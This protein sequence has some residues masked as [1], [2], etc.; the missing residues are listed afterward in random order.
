MTTVRT[1]LGL[2]GLRPHPSTAQ[3][4]LD[5]AVTRIYV[6]ELP[7][8][9]RYLTAGELVLSGLLW[10]RAPGDA[11]PFVA[12][13]A[14]S[15]AAA[16]AAS[17]ADAGGIPADVVDTCARHGIPLLEVPP[18]LS[19]A[20]V[21]ER[22]VLALAAAADGARKRLLTAAAEDAPLDDLLARAAEELG[23]ACWV[24]SGV[25]RVV[26]G[27][28]ALPVSAAEPVRQF[29]AARARPTAAGGLTVLPVESRHAVPWL[30][31]VDGPLSTAQT[32]LAEELAGLVG[33][34]RA[35]SRLT[36]APLGGQVRAVA[37]RT[38][39]SAEAD[40]VLAELLA[41]TGLAVTPTGSHDHS[42]A[43]ALVA[44]DGSWPAGWADDAVTALSTVEPLLR[45]TRILAGVSDAVPAAESRG[46]FEVARHALSLAAGREGDVVVVPAAE[47]GVHQLLLAGTSVDLRA[48]L[49][50][51]LL[52]PLLD[53]DAEQHSDLVHTV[54]VFLEC[55]GSPTRAAKA[56]H[57]HV[58]TLRYR[59]G[60]A[61]EL[62][63]VDLTDF[64]AQV[65][66]Y[67]TLTSES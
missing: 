33:L 60:R 30:L 50:R 5:R 56:L 17:G 10:W 48:A 57:I 59:I 49:R 45:A 11:E 14:A 18:D 28:A 62:L 7:D 32:E 19:F 47:V 16:L 27:T 29:A 3:D 67:L 42:E 65:D 44:D 2:P 20:V 64:V 41:T 15:G 35:R 58:N 1:L 6:T 54:R 21:T 13:L 37:L 46:A 40:D 25:P 26:A 36:A 22:V 53:Y 51:R 61:A 24:L 55:S 23:T 38:P 66:V 9:G 31:A 34:A 12:A 43:L 4:L 63:G 39:D 52:G 8:P